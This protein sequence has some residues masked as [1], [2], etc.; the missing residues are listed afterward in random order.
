M[1]VIAG[2]A[3]GR[4]L[5]SFSGFSVRPTPSR[6]REA[7]FSMLLSRLGSFDGLKVLDLFAGSGALAIEAL[8]RGAASACL[9]EQ[10]KAAVKVVRD[11]LALCRLTDRA[12][13]LVGDVWKIL[14]S[15]VAAAPFDIIFLDPPYNRGMAARA[16]AE[17]AALG[18]L[19]PDGIQ[20]AE[21]AAGE[22]LPEAAGGLRRCDH[23]RYGTVMISLYSN[24][25]QGQP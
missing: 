2:S 9:V 5:A 13:V 14:P 12:D 20:S 15:L 6:V 19:A 3:R 23:R 8:S 4:R 21:T 1:R 16:I 10:D 11:N 17:V 24:S 22:T 7:L 18:L 25:G